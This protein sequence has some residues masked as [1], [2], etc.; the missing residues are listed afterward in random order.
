M[1]AS[2]GT[3][4]AAG[5]ESAGYIGQSMVLSSLFPILMSAAVLIFALL[6]SKS[7]V[8]MIVE[9]SYIDAL[10]LLAYPMIVVFCLQTT[11]LSGGAEWQFGNMKGDQKLVKEFVDN[12]VKAYVSLPFELFNRFVSGIS[13]LGI[14][15]ILENP[16]SGTVLFSVRQQMLDS[17]LNV[18]LVSSGLRS[19][20]HEGL[21]GKCGSW[22]DAAR[23]IGRG[24]RDPMYQ[25]TP[26]YTRCMC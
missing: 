24:N 16:I 13:Q 26:D 23:K 7:L 15:L 25:G 22:M 1:S 19:L 3:L 10:K 21:Q 2:T 4:V 9:G 17:I 6:S 11:T 8:T 18:D 14:G 12:N 20:V 5:L